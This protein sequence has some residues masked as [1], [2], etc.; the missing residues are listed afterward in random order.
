MPTLAHVAVPNSSWIRVD[1][2]LDGQEELDGAAWSLE[3]QAAVGPEP[4]S[5]SRG[6]RLPSTPRRRSEA[7]AHQRHVRVQPLVA[8]TPASSSHW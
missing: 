6:P 5:A 4:R 8:R 7:A 3:A 1:P 2:A